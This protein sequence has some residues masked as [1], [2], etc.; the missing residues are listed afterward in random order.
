MHPG[1]VVAVQAGMLRT[2]VDFRLQDE[3]LVTLWFTKNWKLSD[4]GFM[5][6]TADQNL[7]R[8]EYLYR[9]D[10]SGLAALRATAGADAAGGRKRDL[11]HAI[12]L[13]LGYAADK[14]ALYD[15]LVEIAG[16]SR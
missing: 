5:A 10:A 9:G 16:A 4:A 7:A 13:H 6:F 3:L 8:G 15:R 12:G 1:E 11:L 2:S 14:Q